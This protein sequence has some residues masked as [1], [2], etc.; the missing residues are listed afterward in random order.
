MKPGLTIHIKLKGVR[1]RVRDALKSSSRD[2]SEVVIVAVSKLHSAES[3][4]AAIM[5][6]V[7]DL[8]ENRVQEAEE[9]RPRVEKILT[10][11]GFDYSK[12]RWHLVGQLQSNKTRKAASLFE[13]V[14]SLESVKIARRLSNAAVEAGKTIDVFI[15]VNT[16]GEISKAG[17]HPQHAVELVKEVYSFPGIRIKG[18]M[19]V[20]PNTDDENSITDAFRLLRS[21]RGDMLAA[22]PPGSVGEE[23]S[24]GMSG[25][26][27]LAIRAGSTVVRIGTAIFGPRP[28]RKGCHIIPPTGGKSL[29]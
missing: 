12:V 17:V 26:F 1:Q 19:T 11:K 28:A 5:A 23:L 9:K 10:E 7:T 22:M 18:L 8:G 14:Q 24:M 6:G 2:E 16:S 15:E 21:L 25:D 3:V 29:A 4:A 27:P 20:G 13:V